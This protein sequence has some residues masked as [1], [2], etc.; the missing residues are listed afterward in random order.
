[1]NIFLTNRR[2]LH[3]L[4]ALILI[5]L[6]SGRAWAQARLENPQPLSFQSG[7]GVVSGW[8][9]DASRVDIEFDGAFTLQAAYGTSRADT[10]P[11][12]FCGDDGN[13]GFGLLFNWNIL[14]DGVHTVRALADGVE[15]ARAAFLVTTLGRGEFVP[16]LSR[17]VQIANFPQTGASTQLQWQEAQQNF[18]ISGGSMGGG[19]G[20]TLPRTNLENPQPA[21]FQSGIGVVSGWAC[22]ASRVDIEFDGAFTLQAAYGTSRADTAPPEFCGDDGNNGFGLLFNW[23]LLGDGLH[24]VRAL[25]DGVEFAN[26]TFTVTTLGLGEF[27]QGLSGNTLVTNFPQAGTSMRLQW[28][29]SQQ[30]FPLA[31]ALPPGVSA[32]QCTTQQGAA[33]DG[34]GGRAVQT[35]TNACL[36]AGNAILGKIQAIAGG[37]VTEGAAV[38]AQST[39]GFFLCG[40]ALAFSQGN[41]VFGSATFALLDGEGNEVCEELPPGTERDVFVRLEDGSPLNFNQPFGI[42]YAGQS[43][44]SFRPTP[45]PQCRLS[46]APTQLDF[47]TVPVGQ[48]KDLSFQVT[49]SGA[50]TLTGEAQ[51]GFDLDFFSI[52]SGGQFSNL[53][54]GQSQTVTVRFSPTEPVTM[55]GGISVTSNCGS[56][57]VSVTGTGAVA[58]QLAVSPNQLDFGEVPLNTRKTLTLTITNVGG[59]ILSGDIFFTFEGTVEGSG[60]LTVGPLG[61]GESANFEFFV[62]AT[63]TE[64]GPFSGSVDITSNGGSVSVPITGTIVDDSLN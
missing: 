31:G 33:G 7:I 52:V 15:F 26:V 53:G 41:Q 10:A 44:V 55:T 11:P 32:E 62:D 61:P 27:A 4:H 60:E 18:L 57:L 59:G 6:C 3:A 5:L 50:D 23:N 16:G 51:V 58:P 25:A 45:T 54:P 9:C 43:V 14:T 28:Q 63:G 39:G 13:N 12:E 19:G 29:E 17:T 36:L 35:W 24:N 38:R 56:D 20:T 8:A 21:S 48:S 49:N 40:D 1:M 46:V 2:L 30:N 22:D 47:G 64:L 34:T 42:N 37:A